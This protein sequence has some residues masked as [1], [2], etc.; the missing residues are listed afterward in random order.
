[1]DKGLILARGSDIFKYTREEAGMYHRTYMT[2]RERDARSRLGK[3]VHDLPLLKGAVVEMKRTCGKERCRC[4]Q[5]HRHRSLYLSVSLEG[6]RKLI[7]VPRELEQ[8]ARQWVDNYKQ[9]RR[10]IGGVSGQCL[11]RLLKNKQRLKDEKI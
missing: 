1:M 10:L 11:E 8:Q 6:E 2:R 4:L 5:G 7:Y 9:V 3:I